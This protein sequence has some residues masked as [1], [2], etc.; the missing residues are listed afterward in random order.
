MRRN[1]TDTFSWTALEAKAAGGAP[2]E[3]VDFAD[4]LEA[5]RPNTEKQRDAEGVYGEALVVRDMDACDGILAEERLEDAEWVNWSDV[6][7]D[8]QRQD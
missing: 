3:T 8:L 5:T 7:R 6:K 4:I 1:A 2:S